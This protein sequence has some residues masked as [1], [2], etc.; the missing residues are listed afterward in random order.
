MKYKSRLKPSYG[1][2]ITPM[3]DVVFLLLIFF[4]VTYTHADRTAQTVNLPRSSSSSQIQNNKILIVSLK[5][6]GSIY[7]GNERV[8]K[9]ILIN[10]IKEYI[11]RTSKKQMILRGD[12]LVPYGKLMEIMDI[13]KNS[14]IEKISL[15]T[16]F[17]KVNSR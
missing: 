13:A 3:I 2:M 10:K 15:S 16:R 7:V 8:I 17:K 9:T 12:K 14:G 6:D 1:M 5:K 11:K 4:M